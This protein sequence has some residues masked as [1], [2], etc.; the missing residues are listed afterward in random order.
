[1]SPVRMLGIE[2]K[3][4]PGALPWCAPS[5]KGGAGVGP[6]SGDAE[7]TWWCLLPAMIAVA[8]TGCSTVA[9]SREDADT[10]TAAG[11]DSLPDTP[12]PTDRPEEV[13]AGPEDEGTETPAD[14]DCPMCGQ[15]CDGRPATC[16]Y[17]CCPTEY[18]RPDVL[19]NWPMYCRYPDFE[20]S[21]DL[22]H[23]PYRA[24]SRLQFLRSPIMVD[25]AGASELQPI[26][27]WTFRAD[28]SELVLYAEWVDCWG[29]RM[30]DA[31][32][33]ADPASYCGRNGSHGCCAHH[34]WVDETTLAYVVDRFR[35]ELLHAE[36]VPWESREVFGFDRGREGC[37]LRSDVFC[38]D[39]LDDD[40]TYFAGTGPEWSLGPYRGVWWVLPFWRLPVSSAD[41]H[42]FELPLVRGAVHIYRTSTREHI[43]S[44]DLIL[45]QPG[46]TW[47]P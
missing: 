35:G 40:V 9:T 37:A 22:V 29:F 34:C 12:E 20:P 31:V 18:F 46:E 14:S 5:P 23:G 19:D 3:R 43:G 47:P 28:G 27:G 38:I 15:I 25:A 10:T 30:P 4:S 44:I 7:T 42:L 32:W 36:T 41:S 11:D 2:C 1:M 6:A 8:V 24:W 16:G 39:V 45:L 21:G 33:G 13:D 26:T 17:Y